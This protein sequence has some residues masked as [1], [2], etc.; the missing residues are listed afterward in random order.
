MFGG[1]TVTCD[2]ASDSDL[3]TVWREH[4]DAARLVDKR[5]SRLLPERVESLIFLNRNNKWP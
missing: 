1:G 2:V 3:L 4:A 5:C